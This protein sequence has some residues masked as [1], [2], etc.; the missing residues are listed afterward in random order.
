MSAGV[1]LPVAKSLY[2]CDGHL[3]FTSRK[4]DLMGIFD[5]IRPQGG[6]PH[7]HPSFVVF[8][9]LAQGLGTIPFRVDIRLDASGQF[10]AGTL[11]QQLVFPGRDTI[12]NMVVTVKGGFLSP[13]GNF[14][15]RIT[16]GQS[17][18]GRHHRGTKMRRRAHDRDAAT[19]PESSERDVRFGPDTAFRMRGPF[20]GPPG[21]SGPRARPTTTLATLQSNRAGSPTRTGRE[22]EGT[23]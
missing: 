15:G 12:V 18:G 7:I 23:S 8:A 20:H 6:Y 21:D 19:D 11:V 14:P 1:I 10:V 17:V 3:G 9:R 4:T 16:A 2:L 22:K 13:A 5:S